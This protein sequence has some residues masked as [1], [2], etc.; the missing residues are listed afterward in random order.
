MA[1]R[2]SDL[3]NGK[4]A[5]RMADEKSKKPD[6]EC[7]DPRILME[8]TGDDLIELDSSSS[9]AVNNHKL[10][11][12]DISEAINH[13]SDVFN[14]TLDGDDGEYR[15][16]GGQSFD[17]LTVGAIADEFILSG[18]SFDNDRVTDFED[19]VDLIVFR[20]STGVTEFADISQ[21]GS[22]V[23]IETAAGNIRLKNTDVADVTEA[24][25]IFG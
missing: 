25:F 3:E 2:Y 9:A 8:T 12:D 6:T 23:V 7:P 15:L 14:R 11:V 20:A 24:D 10:G 5:F 18:A 4:P 21:A 1:A 16:N 22:D 13:G 17:V 19:G